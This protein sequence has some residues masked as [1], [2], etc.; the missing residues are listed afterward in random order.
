MRHQV[1]A[2]AGQSPDEY[3]ALAYFTARIRT[4]GGGKRPT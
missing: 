4:A 1:R 2:D 3:S